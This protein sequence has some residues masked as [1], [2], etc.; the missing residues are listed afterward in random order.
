MK[1]L[2]LLLGL[3]ALSPTAQASIITY[4]AS[5]SGANENPPTASPGTGF[6][7]F[8]VDTVANTVLV[9][10]SFS[11][12]TSND[13]AA[14]IHCCV[15]PGGNTGVATALPALP[16]F[17]LGVTSGSYTN[18]LFSLLDPAF[19]N[20]SF[21]TANGGT[22]ASAEAVLLAGFAAGTTYFNIHTSVN[23]GGEIRGFLTAT[24]ATPEPA[25][26]VLMSL[27]LAGL[28]LERLVARRKAAAAS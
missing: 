4:A 2:S 11:G 3:V 13:T 5:L 15:A 6:A 24:T 17:P 7:S 26:L 9:N 8:T 10:V 19:Y 22:T 28:V 18:Q 12:L 27:A 20:P 23:P 16:G 14:H 21:V 1:G 25:T